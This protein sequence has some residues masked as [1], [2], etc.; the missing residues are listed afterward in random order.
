MLDL[1]EEPIKENIE[2]CKKYLERMSKIGMVLE[3]ELGVTGGEEDGVDNTGIDSSKLYTQP[4]DVAY[5]YEE[6]MK[7]SP[8]FTIAAAG[9]VRASIEA[10][11]REA[12]VEELLPDPSAPLDENAPMF[13]ICVVAPVCGSTWLAIGGRPAMLR[14]LFSL[15][16]M[17]QPPRSTSTNGCCELMTREMGKVLTET[18]GDTQEGIDTAYYAASEGRRLFGHT[19]PSELPNKFNMAMKVPIGVAGIITPWNFPM[20]IPTWKI[21]PALVS[22]NTVVFKPASDTP[23]TATVNGTSWFVA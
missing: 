8:R 18:R 20:A 16:C 14:G 12:M 3:I 7:V 13:P 17:S 19:V 21:F 6:L 4:E 22:G 2:T 10:R 15:A 11:V 5:A 1:S 23:A 9:D